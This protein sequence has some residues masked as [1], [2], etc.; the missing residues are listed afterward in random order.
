MLDVKF[1]KNRPKRH[2]VWFK[3]YKYDWW[4]L[5]GRINKTEG[6]QLKRWHSIP[7]YSRHEI[8]ITGKVR[9]KI[10]KKILK[11][12]YPGNGYGQV[13]VYNNAKGKGVSTCVHQLLAITFLGKRPKGMWISFKDGNKQ[14]CHYRNIYYRKP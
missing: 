5:E 7:N 1:W 13:N 6:K 3:I 8:T 14:N 9:H 4:C 12:A 10:H 2:G 11:V